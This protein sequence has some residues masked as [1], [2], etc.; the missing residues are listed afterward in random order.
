[1]SPRLMSPKPMFSRTI[2][3]AA[4]VPKESPNASTKG[5]SYLFRVFAFVAASDLWN[6]SRVL[7]TR[8]IYLLGSAELKPE[9]VVFCFALSSGVA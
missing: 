6:V 5:L 7:G 8:T 4:K 2:F 9:A 3:Q 1:M